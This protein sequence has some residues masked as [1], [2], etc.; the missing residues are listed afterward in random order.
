MRFPHRD[1]IAPVLDPMRQALADRVMEE[2]WVLFIQN[3]D[4]DVNEC[5]GG[6]SSS[7]RRPSR[8]NRN[9]TPSNGPSLQPI[10]RKRQRVEDENADDDNFN[11]PRKPRPSVCPSSS[12]EHTNKFACPFRKH[13]GRRYSVHSHRV[14]TLSSWDSIARVKYINEAFTS[15]HE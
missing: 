2:F 6:A 3:W 11:D 1:I 14:Y 15:S 9:I 4:L 7:S 12:P 10:Q 8:P 5:A 13:D